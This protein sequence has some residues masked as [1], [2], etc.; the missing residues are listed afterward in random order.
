MV[1]ERP[2]LLG[3]FGHSVYRRGWPVLAAMHSKDLS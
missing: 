1:N 3:G 2:S